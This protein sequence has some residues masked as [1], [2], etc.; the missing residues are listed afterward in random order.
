MCQFIACKRR[1]IGIYLYIAVV[2]F[3]VKQYTSTLRQMKVALTT[4]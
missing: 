2:L 3:C 1:I 4:I